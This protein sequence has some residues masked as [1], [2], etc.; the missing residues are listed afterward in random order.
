MPSNIPMVMDMP[1]IDPALTDPTKGNGVTKRVG[2]KLVMRP[3]SLNSA[4]PYAYAQNAILG[5]K[6]KPSGASQGGTSYHYAVELGYNVKMKTQGGLLT[7]DDLVSIGVQNWKYAVEHQE[8]HYA[9]GDSADKMTDDLS[10]GLK[11][12][13]P[14]M[15]IVQ[16]VATEIRWSVAL[17]KP[18]S[19]YSVM[20]GS[21]D[22]LARPSS[23]T[24]GSNVNDVEIVDHKFTSKASTEPKYRLQAGAYR[25]MG[26]SQINEDG[27]PK[28]N[29]T[30][31]V[32]HNMVRGK[33]LKTKYN[34][35]RLTLVRPTWDFP[36]Q[37][38]VFAKM[39]ELIDRAEMVHHLTTEYSIDPEDAVKVMYPTTTPENNYLC[40][41]LWCGFWSICPAN[42]P[43]KMTKFSLVDILKSKAVR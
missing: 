14:T 40:S 33:Q 3:S 31:S 1:L 29:V 37:H 36:T 6:S 38:L 7:P 34:P 19:I 12:Y 22:L 42:N 20:S 11:A 26:A 13:A 28:Y 21:I 2:G 24:I 32:L 30:G 4:C 39:N 27:T 43:D 16:P 15:Q 23:P 10:K 17:P 8:M 41:E 35:P 5:K 9:N 18:S 25:I